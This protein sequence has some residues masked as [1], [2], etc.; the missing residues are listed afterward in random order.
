MTKI[1]YWLISY[2]CANH[3]IYR[4]ILALQLGVY[5]TLTTYPIHLFRN[6]CLL[7]FAPYDTSR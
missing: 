4:I 6:T 3:F 1:R 5:N 2:L 7:S